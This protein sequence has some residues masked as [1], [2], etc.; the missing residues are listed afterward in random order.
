VITYAYDG[1]LRLAGAAENPGATYAYGYDLA[2][3]RTSVTHNGQTTTTSYDAANQVSGWTYDAAGNLLGDGTTSYT[4]DALNRQI[5][6]G[7]TTYTYN[8]DGVLVYDGVMRY[9]QDLVSPLSQILQTTQGLTTTDYLYGANRLASVAGSTR[10]WYL[11]DTLGSV[12][13][14]LSDSGAVL[15][16]V[17]YDPWGTLESGS[18][19][20]FG[21]T[22]ELQD[23]A[24]G[25]VNLRARWYSTA[26]GRFGSRDPFDGFPEQPYSL[27]QYQYGSSDP[28]LQTDPSG[29]NPTLLE[30]MDSDHP[31]YTYSCNCGWI[32]WGH[33]TPNFTAARVI[34]AVDDAITFFADPAHD[35]QDYYLIG[36][37]R[38]DHA[39]HHVSTTYNDVAIRRGKVT[40]S[41]RNQ[42]AMGIFRWVEENTENAQWISG[43]FGFVPF[44]GGLDSYYTE[45]DLASDLI[46]FYGALHG[47]YDQINYEDNPEAYEEYRQFIGQHC[48]FPK[49]P[50]V[51]QLWSL[52]VYID[53]PGFTRD[54]QWEQPI[55]KSLPCIDGYCGAGRAW[56]TAFQRVQPLPGGGAVLG[57]DGLRPL[58]GYEDNTWLIVFGYNGNVNS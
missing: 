57:R 6:R 14:T 46:A 10:T 54:Y 8:G 45:E 20:T 23:S 12:R 49:D 9:T 44:A 51:R 47:G 41:N 58:E 17:N 2:G 28:V 36:K 25:L 42:V 26:Q 21:F 7:A 39:T 3:N 52:Q 35:C 11:G 56:P 34:K 32:D 55:L 15:G 24:A 27:H 22:G 38:I 29:R 48:R 1:L 19:P 5:G 16:T 43:V 13:Q 31:R 4:Y 33:A 40:R 37:E 50:G 53:Y 18:V 30:T